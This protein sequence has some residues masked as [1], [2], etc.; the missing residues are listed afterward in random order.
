MTNQSINEEIRKAIGAHGAWKLR[1][2]SAARAGDT[3][4]PVETLKVDDACDF[5]KWLK[6]VAPQMAGD[7][8]YARIKDMHRAFHAEAGRLAE[9][10]RDG[11]A[12][13]ALAEMDSTGQFTRRS[14]DLTEAMTNWRMS[15]RR[16]RG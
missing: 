11:Q 3:S 12:K 6:S 1:L 13:A 4:L 5:G 14:K 2:T 15:L 9:M 7:P 16:R 10:I 8:D